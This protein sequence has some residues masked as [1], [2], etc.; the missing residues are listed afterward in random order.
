MKKQ[1]FWDQQYAPDHPR[2]TLT[3]SLNKNRRNP[4]AWIIP[5]LWQIT[6]Q[7]TRPAAA[8]AED[9]HPIF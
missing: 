8:A 4:L 1:P 7:I 9:W 3:V 2:H 6:G 5:G